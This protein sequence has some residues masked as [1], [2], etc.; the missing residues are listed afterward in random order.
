MMS[1]VGRVVR[2]KVNIPGRN[3]G[4]IGDTW[5]F[6]HWSTLPGKISQTRGYT[7]SGACTLVLQLW[8][9][10]KGSKTAA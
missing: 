5:G 7:Y 8:C 1:I 6:R 10:V 3:G 2:E 9:W 4:Q